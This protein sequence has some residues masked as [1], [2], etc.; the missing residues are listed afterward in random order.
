[1][2]TQVSSGGTATTPARGC[3]V[4]PKTHAKI[5][6][7]ALQRMMVVEGALMNPRRPKELP[8][9]PE[10]G[11]CIRVSS[12]DKR[13]RRYLERTGYQFVVKVKRALRTADWLVFKYA[14]TRATGPELAA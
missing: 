8:E 7:A 11:L 2:S 6:E 10:I 5:S 9:N 12:N 13:L 4:P 1:M 3:P 14:G